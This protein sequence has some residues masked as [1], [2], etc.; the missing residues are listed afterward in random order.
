[1]PN[2]EEMRAP[3]LDAINQRYYYYHPIDRQ[4]VANELYVL[5]KVYAMVE[6]FTRQEY[7]RACILILERAFRNTT[8]DV[9]NGAAARLHDIYEMWKGGIYHVGS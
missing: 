8:E 1:M 4:T 7:M 2:Y 9:H 6:G 3:I 5:T